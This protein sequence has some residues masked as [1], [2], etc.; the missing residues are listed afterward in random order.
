MNLLLQSE[1]FKSNF[2]YFSESKPNAL[3]DGTYTKVNYC[4]D[5]F[6]M[7]GI[8]IALNNT[9]HETVVRI[10]TDILNAYSEYVNRPTIKTT[11]L[12][13]TKYGTETYLKISGV[14]E[15]TNG[16]IG[17]SFKVLP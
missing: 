17:L 11:K 1:A 16:E 8:H 4:N 9:R 2:V 15:N 13:D 6:T 3:F 14:W 10:E 12:A 5:F 7:N